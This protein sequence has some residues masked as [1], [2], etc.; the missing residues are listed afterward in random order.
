MEP[1]AHRNLVAPLEVSLGS[2]AWPLGRLAATLGKVDVAASWFERAATENERAGAL[3]W[4]AHARLDHSR[5]LLSTG[6]HSGA[7]PL[8]NAAS[9]AYRAL[10]MDAWVARCELATATATA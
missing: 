6:D 2:S 5:L 8:L 7:E 3:P 10:G 1:Y 4:A 9:D